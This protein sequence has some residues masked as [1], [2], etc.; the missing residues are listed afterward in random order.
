MSVNRLEKRAME[1]LTAAVDSH[2][3]FNETIVSLRKRMQQLVR[4]PGY[5]DEAKTIFD[6]YVL[7]CELSATSLPAASCCAFD[8]MLLPLLSHCRQFVER[9]VV[10]P[11]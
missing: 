6:Y 4:R 11:W 9:G 10:G 5:E 7:L 3:Y 8:T 2:D 1:M